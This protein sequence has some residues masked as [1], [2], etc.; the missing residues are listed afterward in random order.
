MKKVRY[1]LIM[2]TVFISL[3][4]AIIISVTIT[5]RN[6]QTNNNLLKIQKEN[7]NND[8]DERIKEQVEIAIS[9]ID[10][11][12][13]K[14]KNGE[15]TIDEA[16]KQSADLLRKLKFGE[17]GYFWADNIDGTNIVLL[18]SETEG[19]NRLDTKDST[20]KYL[21]KEII[22]NGKKEGGGY[23]DYWFP[24]S[25][26]TEAS[27]KR[28]YSKLY[29]PYNWIIGTGNYIDNIDEVILERE[30]ILKKDI[31]VGIIINVFLVI[32]ALIVAVILSV[33]TSKQLTNPL[34]KIKDFAL[35]L[36]GYDFSNPIHIRS[37]DEF[38]QTA[39]ALN[40]AQ[41]NVKTL[42][43]LIIDESQNIGASSEELSAT[44]EELF[45]KIVII[46]EAVESITS[47]IQESGAV[48]EEISASIEEVDSSINVLS[49]KSMDGSNISNAAKERALAVKDNSN[50]AIEETREVYNEKK[51]KMEK[52]IEAV[53][54]VESIKVMADTIG[55]I[56]DQTNLLALNAAIEAARAGEQGKGFAVVADEV[57]KLAEQSSN[58]VGN[59]QETILK[60]QYA[61]KNSIEA[62]SEILE[63]INSN[64]NMQLDA[65]GE[66]GAKYYDDSEFVSQ[67]SDEI[68][69]MSEEITATVGQVSEAVQSMAESSQ[70]SS[71]KAEDIRES[72]RETTKAIEQIAK[73]AQS[74]AE[75]AQKLNEMVQKFNI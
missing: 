21:I 35:R 39:E 68:A 57:R 52:A 36:S 62:G 61:F 58:A 73:T 65:Y 67:M 60:V 29:T 26:E 15:I 75:L 33:I 72:M 25:G 5:F 59:I 14:A 8:Y 42:V 34:I 1:K 37:K 48:T 43:S 45:S 50:K 23:T 17:D 38:G 10:A 7:L 71:E 31:Q 40:E 70:E 55:N 64:V 49:G 56:A 11:I 44:V 2:L 41:K 18:G 28:G 19:T 47:A 9:M 51:E 66:T 16:K 22:E 24:K 20:G 30:Y 54:V 46:D 4:T 32:G 3:V 13:E 6:I 27:L 69:A 74:Q 53:M 12:N 63:F